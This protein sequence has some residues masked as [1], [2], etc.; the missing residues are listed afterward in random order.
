MTDFQSD[1]EPPPHEQLPNWDAH[2]KVHE[3]TL[4]FFEEVDQGDIA[5]GTNAL[6]HCE[7]EIQHSAPNSR[8]HGRNNCDKILIRESLGNAGLSAVGPAMPD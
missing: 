1:L 5:C 4:D 7:A 6:G 3:G 2:V 8:S